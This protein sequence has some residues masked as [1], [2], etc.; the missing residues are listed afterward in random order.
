MYVPPIH[1]I[2]AQMEHVLMIHLIVQ[3]KL[4]VLLKDQL[5]VMMELVKCQTLNAIKIHNVQVVKRDAQM[6]LV[7]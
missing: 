6:E 7:Y 3:L 5:N 4:F 1:H 2:Y